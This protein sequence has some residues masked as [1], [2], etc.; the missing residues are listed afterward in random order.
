MKHCYLMLALL[1]AIIPL[2]VFIPWL[3]DNG[4]NIGLFYHNVAA[5]PIS[6]FAWLDVLIAAI[7]LIV[8]ITVDAKK[9]QVTGYQFAILGTLCIGVSFGLPFYLYLKCVNGRALLQRG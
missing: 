3:F 6:L 4:I 8:F 2:G 9:R 7:V 5:N 1:G